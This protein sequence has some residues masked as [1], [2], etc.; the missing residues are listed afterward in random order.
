MQGTG[1][2]R[3][4]GSQSHDT[5]NGKDNSA[6][7]RWALQV[8]VQVT[9]RMQGRPVMDCGLR[10]P[11]LSQWWRGEE[12]GLSLALPLNYDGKGESVL[13][14]A[15]RKSR[16]RNVSVLSDMAGK[17]CTEF[18]VFALVAIWLYLVSLIL[19]SALLDNQLR[20]G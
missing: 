14:M 8:L 16:N 10:L 15:E 1:Y 18:V 4:R 9:K 5:E 6:L 3:K 13:M 19:I 11:F 2:L 17:S 12:S 20:H 7:K